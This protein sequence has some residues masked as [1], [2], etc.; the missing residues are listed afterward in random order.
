MKLN[1]LLIA[2]GLLAATLPVIAGTLTVEFSIPAGAEGKIFAGL[3]DTAEKFPKQGSEK[4]GQMAEAK[5]NKVT[6]V[7]NDLAA[8]RYAISAYLDRNGNQALDT[9]ILGVP[10]E[11][12]GFSRDA[13][14]TVGPPGFAEAAIEHDGKDQTISIELK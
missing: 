9:N 1:Q 3:Y 13:R 6:L 7:F 10:K 8:G 4:M 14:G 12:Y 11:P 2:G 5:G